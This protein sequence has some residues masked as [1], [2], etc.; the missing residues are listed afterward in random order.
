MKTR[1]LI[2]GGGPC[3]VLMS[4]FLSKFRIPSILIET[5]GREPISHPRAHVLNTRSME[6]MRKV[7]YRFFLLTKNCFN[8]KSS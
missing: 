5:G 2:V 3:G 6:I 1:V 4:I 8:N 7:R